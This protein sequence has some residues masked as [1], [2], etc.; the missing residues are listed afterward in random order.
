M[1]W[2]LLTSTLCN[3]KIYNIV[4]L[5]IVIVLY[6]SHPRTYSS[7]NWKFV[8]LDHLQGGPP[9]PLAINSLFFVSI[10]WFFL[11]SKYKWGHSIFVFVR[12]ISLSIMCSFHVTNG[13]ICNTPFCLCM[14]AAFLYPL[15]YWWTLRLL[16]LPFWLRILLQCRKPRFDPWVGKEMATHSSI[17]A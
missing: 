9:L 12:L 6:T 13:W 17:L 4:I 8:P 5:T 10:I 3:F 14:C 15:T 1:W 16:G 7:Y 11:D 2:V